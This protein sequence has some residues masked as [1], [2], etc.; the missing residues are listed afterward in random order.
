MS[1]SFERAVG[2]V[3]ELEGADSNHPNDNG[4]LTRWG[5]SQRAHPT[6]DFD[7]LT[8]EKAIAIYKREYWAKI[9]GDELPAALA[10]VL[11]DWAVHAGRGTAVQ[12]LQ[13][14]VG[15]TQD[16][17]LGKRTLAAALRFE[18]RALVLELLRLRSRELVELAEKPGQGVFAVGW[19][20]RI[21]RVAL[22][23]GR[24]L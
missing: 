24:L 15:A 11:F 19:Q 12:R 3:L 8:R 14:L 21:A 2:L 4:Q 20:A 1:G 7:S 13:R 18:P 16:G 17:I 6:L 9:L 23:A 22:E 10:L 5:L